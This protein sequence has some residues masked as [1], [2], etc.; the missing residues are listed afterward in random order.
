V[1]RGFQKALLALAA[2][3]ALVSLAACVSVDKLMFHPPRP[4]YGEDLPGLVRIEDGGGA[5]AALWSP[6]GDAEGAVLFFHGNAE[7]IR[8]HSA[9]LRRFNRLGW[10]AM[11]VD[12]P[13]YGRSEGT[14]TEKGAYRAAEAGWR[15]L[16]ETQ[17]IA[18]E[19]VVV[20]GFSIGTGPACWLAAKHEPAGLLLF[21]PFK[22]AVRVVTRIRLLPFDP[23]PNLANVKRAKCPVAVV[24][25]THD[26]VIPFSQG[27][28]VAAAA[29]DRAT[30]FAVRGAD[31]NGLLA[32]LSDGDL[33]EALDAA[34]GKAERP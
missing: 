2:L 8:F 23:F 4:P 32:A 10:S 7:D 27:Q 17:G 12:Y 5:V 34:L 30:F 33:R 18:P 29:G 16:T 22:S 15:F 31:H 25:G 28:A 26:D 11:A 24:H 6:A 20:C 3:W 1:K 9:T 19:K 13:G 21:A 14:P